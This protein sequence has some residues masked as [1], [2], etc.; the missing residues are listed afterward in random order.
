MHSHTKWYKEHSFVHA[1][2]DLCPWLTD[3]GSLTQRL[4]SLS[5]AFSVIRLKQCQQLCL[6]DEYKMWHG[7][8]RQ[9]YPQREVL[10]LCDNIPLVWGYTIVVSHAVMRDWPFYQRLGTMPLGQRLFKDHSIYRGELE[11]SRLYEG[12]PY[13]KRLNRVLPVPIVDNPLYARRSM[14]YRRQGAMLVTEVF[15]PAI[16]PL[17]AS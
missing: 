17:I 7:K 13:V 11:F 4:K 16:N 10:L 9:Y 3:R 6:S 15:L 1:P 12:H 14:F 8:S 5:S 2:D